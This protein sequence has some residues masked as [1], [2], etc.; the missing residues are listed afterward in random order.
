VGG[1]GGVAVRK[2]GKEDEN[3]KSENGREEGKRNEGLTWEGGHE[4]VAEREYLGEKG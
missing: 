4:G 3:E 2:L 1:I